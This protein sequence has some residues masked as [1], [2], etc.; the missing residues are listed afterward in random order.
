[1]TK[2]LTRALVFVA[3]LASLS[4]LSLEMNERSLFDHSANGSVTFSDYKAQKP[5]GI[6]VISNPSSATALTLPTTATKHAIITVRYAGVIMRDDGT[7]PTTTTGLYLPKGTVLTVPN[8][9]QWLLAMKFI[10]TADEGA[11]TVY[12]AYYEDR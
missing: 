4:T 10:N 12:I 7:N 1:M 9:R 2:H 8:D 3:L 6:Q 5:S 11:S